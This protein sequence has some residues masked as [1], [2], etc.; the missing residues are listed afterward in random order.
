MPLIRFPLP[1]RWKLCLKLSK[2]KS[3]FSVQLPSPNVPN[4]ASTIRIPRSG[5][6]YA[7]STLHSIRL[8][9]LVLVF[10]KLSK[11]RQSRIARSCSFRI[12][13]LFGPIPATMYVKKCLFLCTIQS[14]LSS[15][16]PTSFNNMKGTNKQHNQTYKKDSL[17][18]MK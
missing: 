2:D 10:P 6:F 13:N 14:I 5:K 1:D 7:W 9:Y 18:V 17:V 3:L 8:N 16:Y 12:L 11:A 4:N 15:S